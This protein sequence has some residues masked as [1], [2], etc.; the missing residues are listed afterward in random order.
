[1]EGGNM[2]YFCIVEFLGK[3]IVVTGNPHNAAELDVV[4]LLC[5]VSS[6]DPDRSFKSA[7]SGLEA[8]LLNGPLCIQS[9]RED[10]I[11]LFELFPIRL[12]QSN[13]SSRRFGHRE[14]LSIDGPHE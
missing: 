11:T 8:G 7:T 12:G 3:A 2:K 6:G 14:L 5:R 10:R 13:F 9:F 4:K 1:M